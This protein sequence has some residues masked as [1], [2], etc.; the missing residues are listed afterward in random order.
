M[1]EVFKG[2]SAV[3]IRLQLKGREVTHG[4]QRGGTWDVAKWNGAGRQGWR[5]PGSTFLVSC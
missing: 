5:G 4:K 1:R 3:L 2:A